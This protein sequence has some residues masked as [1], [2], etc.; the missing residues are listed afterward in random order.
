MFTPQVTGQ[1]QIFR[2]YKYFYFYLVRNF[3]KHINLLKIILMWNFLASW[4]FY[5][6]TKP[7]RLLSNL[8][9]PGESTGN[10][11]RRFMLVTIILRKKTKKYLHCFL[12]L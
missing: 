10:L 3:E 1:K 11:N 5:H 2:L 8:L 7:R 12:T 9:Q 4:Y 6:M